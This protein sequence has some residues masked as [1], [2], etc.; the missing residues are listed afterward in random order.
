M[1]R[2][3]RHRSRVTAVIGLAVCCG[4]ATIAALVAV[5]D[6]GDGVRPRYN[7]RDAAPAELSRTQLE[8]LLL[9][10]D[11][12]EAAQDQ[13]EPDSSILQPPKP[14]ANGQA[15]R[16][17]PTQTDAVEFPDL[18]R[19]L[20]DS[21]RGIRLMTRD[22]VPPNPAGEYFAGTG[23]VTHDEGFQRPWPHVQFFWMAS[24][25]VHY[26]LY[27][28]D[29]NLERYGYSYGCA[30]PVVSAA[31]FFGRIPALPYLMTLEPPCECQYA[32]GYFRPG[33][34]APYRLH[35]PPLDARAAFVEGATITG[36]VFLIP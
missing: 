31:H 2:I 26:P 12:F 27:F 36:L 11:Q 17:D 30:Q 35:W 15:P 21:P 8:R 6:A 32:L 28:E 13:G 24:G 34:C 5:A 14:P 18:S 29:I 10:V 19:P 1:T 25:A 7:R 16:T 4:A 33:S 23:E 9:P 20:R 22:F 3:N